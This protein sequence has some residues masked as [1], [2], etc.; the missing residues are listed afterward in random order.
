MRNN[1][2][3]ERKRTI[4]IKAL[5]CKLNQIVYTKKERRNAHPLKVTYDKKL[6]ILNKK[7]NYSSV[8]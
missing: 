3:K 1:L 5:T 6:V 2:T 4:Q 8:K 7:N